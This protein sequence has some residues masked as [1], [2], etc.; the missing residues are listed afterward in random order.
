MASLN[1]RI[2]IWHSYWR[3]NITPIQEDPEVLAGRQAEDLL[4]IVVEGHYKFKG[5]HSFPS[6]RV[7]V[8]DRNE[9]REIDVIVATDKKLYILE[10]KN[11]SGRLAQRGNQWVQYKRDGTFQENTDVVYDNQTK[12]SVLRRYLGSRGISVEPDDCEHRV[13]FMNPHLQIVSPEIAN[14]RYVITANRLEEY[15]AQQD[16]RLK[17]HQRFLSSLIGLLLASEN[18]EKIIDGLFKRLGRGRYQSLIQVLTDLPTW[19]KVEYWGQTTKESVPKI[20]PG[21]VISD[22]IAVDRIPFPETKRIEV[23]ISRNKV[24]GLVNAVFG[25]ERAI[26]LDCYDAN[27]RCILKTE[28]LDPQATIRFIPAGRP[29]RVEIPIFNITRIRYGR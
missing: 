12:L 22:R 29:E 20:A 19:D 2:H 3:A 15:L 8:L 17:P 25:L 10:C 11:W 1:E 26:G 6:K 13:I 5:A 9:K 21:D 7:P 18:A 23:R 16:N 4:R 14:N 28:V 24:G 27:D